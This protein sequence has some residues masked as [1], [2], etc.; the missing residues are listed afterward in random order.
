MPGT[1]YY[2]FMHKNAKEK[3]NVHLCIRTIS[4]LKSTIRETKVN[5]LKFG[6]NNITIHKTTYEDQFVKKNKI[7]K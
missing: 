7:A 6:R 3:K 5:R 2:L 1:T 4:C